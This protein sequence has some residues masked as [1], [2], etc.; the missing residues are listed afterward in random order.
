MIRQTYPAT[1]VII[2]PYTYQYVHYSSIA[3]LETQV[4]QYLVIATWAVRHFQRKPIVSD[5][6]GVTVQLSTA[7][8]LEIGNAFY[9]IYVY[10]A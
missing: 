2:G 10:S 3:V 4:Q 5:N 8:V 6:P 1:W 7:R 9:T